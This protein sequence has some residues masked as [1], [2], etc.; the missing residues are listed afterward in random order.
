MTAVVA[1][2]RA[3]LGA[4][5]AVPLAHATRARPVWGWE[6][7][8]PVTLLVGFAPGVGTDAISRLLQPSLQADLG[9]PVTVTN[10]ISRLF[11]PSPQASFGQ[12]TAA[13]NRPGASDTVAALSGTRA[14]PDGQ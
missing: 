7:S 3:V 2:R 11:Q 14:P 10:I 1:T 13:E 9:R 12:P 5:A 4:A 6:P 8:R